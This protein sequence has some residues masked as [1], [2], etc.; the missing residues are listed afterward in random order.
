MGHAQR[1]RGLVSTENGGAQ[2]PGLRLL[3]LLLQQDR[4]PARS[5]G[6]QVAASLEPGCSGREPFIR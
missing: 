4:R 3:W 6:Q 1:E 2:L 5:A